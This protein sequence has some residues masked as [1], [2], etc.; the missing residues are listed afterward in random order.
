[1][2]VLRACGD[3]EPI[4]TVFTYFPVYHHLYFTDEAFFVKRAFISG[5]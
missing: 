1:M 5:L 4:M 2:T 3:E